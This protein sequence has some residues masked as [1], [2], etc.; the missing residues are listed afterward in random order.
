[1]DLLIPTIKTV[2]RIFAVLEI[3]AV[4]TKK[5]AMR[6]HGRIAAITFAVIQITVVIGIV[7]RVSKGPKRT[8]VVRWPLFHPKTFR[9]T[10]GVGKIVTRGFLIVDIKILRPERL[11]QKQFI[12]RRLPFFNQCDFI[13]FGISI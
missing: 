12:K 9:A 5:R 2:D 10:D 4:Q 1:M 7:V 13:G 11:L 6:I 8:E 3:I